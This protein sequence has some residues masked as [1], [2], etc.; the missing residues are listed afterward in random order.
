MTSPQQMS[1]HPGTLC[2]IMWRHSSRHYFVLVL[3]FL[4]GLECGFH[5]V[6]SLAGL[7]SFRI[8]FGV[9]PDL[10]SKTTDE[11]ETEVSLCWG[12]RFPFRICSISDNSA[13]S[14]RS[15]SRHPA[16]PGSRA[17]RS[18]WTVSWKSIGLARDRDFVNMEAFANIF[19]KK[20]FHKLWMIYFLISFWHRSCINSKILRVTTQNVSV[21]SSGN[22]HLVSFK[23]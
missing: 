7:T 8:V 9:Q 4:I 17:E 21:Y 10:S 2:S 20:V 19:E 1:C 6:I 23:Q 14:T 13:C 22:K 3:I 15:S 11:G 5:S 18:L 12:V 16:V